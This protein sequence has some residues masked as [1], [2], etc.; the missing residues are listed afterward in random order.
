MRSP[1]PAHQ[2]RVRYHETDAQGIVFNSRYL[3]FMDVALAEHFRAL[4]WSLSEL[5]TAGLDPA[6]V[7]VQLDFH[8]PATLDD[9]LDIHVECL[10]IGK[11]SF[12]MGFEVLQHQGKGDLVSSAQITYV[13]YDAVTASSRPMPAAVRIMLAPE[14]MQ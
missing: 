1:T 9:L 14:A 2:H 11:S 12:V 7:H 5:A 13:N 8:R 3:E 6:L 10:R 4:G